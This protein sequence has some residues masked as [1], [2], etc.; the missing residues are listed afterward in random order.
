M[1]KII[2][3]TLLLLI[4]NA[5]LFA[6]SN[7]QE[8]YIVNLTQDTIKG[9]ID[10]TSSIANE[11]KC[12][13]KIA[14]ADE[15][16]SYSPAEIMAYGINNHRYYESRYVNFNKAGYRQ[17]FIEKIIEGR[18]SLFKYNETFFVQKDNTTLIQLENNKTQIEKKDR[19][20]LVY[21]N[22]YIGTLVHLTKD[23]PEMHKDVQNCVLTERSLTNLLEKYNSIIGAPNIIFKTDLPWTKIQIGLNGGYTFSNLNIVSNEYGVDYLTNA[24]DLAYAPAFNAYIDIAS[25]RLSE[26]FKFTLG[27]NYFYAKYLKYY[28]QDKFEG[29]TYSDVKIEINAISIPIGIRYALPIKSIDL[30]FST[31]IAYSFII[32]QKTN[33]EQDIVKSGSVETNSVPNFLNNKNQSSYWLSIGLSKAINPKMD[34]LIE[35]KFERGNGYSNEVFLEEYLEN[36]NWVYPHISNFQIMFGLR[37]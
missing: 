8:G 37:F 19:T 34:G 10:Y 11:K 1:K 21:S 36:A 12:D 14:L 25:P 27:A 33:L 22:Q 30:N 26:K 15:T 7:Y 20:W 18:I 31:G 17:V 5:T 29:K 23:K 4:T 24:W 2:Y 28:I 6:Q 35:F 13:F 32:K 9:Y 3:I 16:T